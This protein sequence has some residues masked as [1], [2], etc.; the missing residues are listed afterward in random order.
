MVNMIEPLSILFLGGVFGLI[1]LS[2]L[3]P[4]YDVMSQFK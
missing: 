4:L 2:I 3:L 1:A